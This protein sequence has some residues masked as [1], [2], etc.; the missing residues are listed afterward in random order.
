MSWLPFAICYVVGLVISTGMFGAYRTENGVPGK[1]IL[2]VTPVWAA[3][4]LWP[5][6]WL[7]FLGLALAM[8]FEKLL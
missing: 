5:L 3:Y 6:Y 1:K 7:F 2:R 8:A 4:V